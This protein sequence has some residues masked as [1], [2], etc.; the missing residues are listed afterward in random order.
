MLCEY[1]ARGLWNCTLPVDPPRG[2]RCR[3]KTCILDYKFARPPKPTGIYQC[4]FV[5]S[6][7]GARP[8]RFRGARCRSTGSDGEAPGTLGPGC[9]NSI[10]SATR[11]EYST[12]PGQQ[13]VGEKV[14]FPH[15]SLIFLQ[16]IS[17]TRKGYSSYNCI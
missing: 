9:A 7:V 13:G 12:I 10:G 15:F 16:P 17:N 4:P 14:I 3:S 2:N 1:F 6:M 5:S 11:S 8:G